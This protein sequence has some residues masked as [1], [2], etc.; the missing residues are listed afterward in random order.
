MQ[1]SNPFTVDDALKAREADQLWKGT[2]KFSQEALS[3]KLFILPV[4]VVVLSN[5][6]VAQEKNAYDRPGVVVVDVLDTRGD[7]H[8]V[9]DDSAGS[10][11]GRC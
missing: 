11:T 7:L 2:R 1:K 10:F 9:N 3:M 6:S 5:C 8:S 4:M